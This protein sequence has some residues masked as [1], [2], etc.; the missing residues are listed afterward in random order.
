MIIGAAGGSRIPTGVFAA[1]FNHL[2]L[3]KS[4]PDALNARRLHHQLTP[5]VLQYETNYDSDIMT[6]LAEK[7]GH[8][9]QENKPD[10]GF[11]AVTGIAIENGQVQAAF[12]NRRGG[13]VEV[14]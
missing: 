12:D 9:L 8:E 2:Y 10:G 6:E 14:F 11:A 7:F 4:L 5:E 1:I 3:N 13:S